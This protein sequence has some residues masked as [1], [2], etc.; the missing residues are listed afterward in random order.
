MQIGAT[1]DK[2]KASRFKPGYD[3]DNWLVAGAE[4]KMDNSLNK[5]QG[6][7]EITES[8]LKQTNS[9]A[10]LILSE[11]GVIQDCSKE[12]AKLLGYIPEDLIHL[13]ISKL[14]PKLIEIELLKAQ[15]INPYLKFLSRVGHQ[16]DL[17]EMNGKRSVS[18]IFFSDIDN[19]RG[20]QLI[21]LINPMIEKK[22]LH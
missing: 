15:R 3:V 12:S 1:Y 16:F 4:E 2:A 5:T 14:L 13:H 18:Q 19:E 20:H 11:D 6:V 17:I 9:F 10:A 7:T 8:G 22:Q 21:V